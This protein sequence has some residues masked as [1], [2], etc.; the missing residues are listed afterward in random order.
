MDICAMPDPSIGDDPI[1]TP[2]STKCTVP[3]AATWARLTTA[4][5]WTVS[6]YVVGLGAWTVSAIGAV[7]LGLAAMTCTGALFGLGSGL[8]V[9]APLFTAGIDRVLWVVPAVADPG[10]RVR[11][12]LATSETRTSRTNL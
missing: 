11:P 10:T 8:A 3:P 4:V 7:G 1:W 12:R 2:P 5:S 9:G 6:P